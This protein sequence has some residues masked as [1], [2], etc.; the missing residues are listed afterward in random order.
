M[1]ILN[2]RSKSLSFINKRMLKWTY[3][4]KSTYVPRGRHFKDTIK[5]R[6]EKNENCFSYTAPKFQDTRA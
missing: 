4:K 1:K 2:F 3:R 5:N 6:N